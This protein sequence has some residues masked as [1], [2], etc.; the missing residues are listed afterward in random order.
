MPAEKGN[1]TGH[2]TTWELWLDEE[3]LVMP[4]AVEQ[5][6]NTLLF[7]GSESRNSG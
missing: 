5:D 7:I 4:P 2:L 1:V 3:L 6:L